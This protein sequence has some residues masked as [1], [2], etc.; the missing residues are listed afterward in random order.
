LEF[1][2]EWGTLHGSLLAVGDA[3]APAGREIVIMRSAERPWVGRWTAVLVVAAVLLSTAGI[4]SFA[5]ETAAF[6][7]TLFDPS[8]KPAEGMVVVFRDVSS[9]K[10]FRSMKTNATGQ[11][12]VSVPVGSR[13]KLQS[14]IAPDGSLVPVQDVPPVPVR[15]PGFNRLDVRFLSGPVRAAQP[16][17]AAAPAPAAA[18]KPENGSKKAVPWW[19]KPAGIVG[20]VL[21]GG[22]AAALAL[23]GGGGG[24]NNN[25]SPSTP[26]N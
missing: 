5:Q 2:V 12:E 15:V 19:K 20:I 6:L 23:G 17:A 7:G 13:F 24:G 4:G 25:P 16:S 1:P 10:E 8:G 14:V 26:D 21:G 11:Y 9:G 3:R 22:A 18:K